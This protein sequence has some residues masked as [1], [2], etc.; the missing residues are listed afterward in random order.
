MRQISG[1]YK[2][3]YDIYTGL[4]KSFPLPIELNMK[5]NFIH[6]NSHPKLNLLI[7]NYPIEDIAGSG[8]DFSKAKKLLHWVSE[9]IYHNGESGPIAKNSLSL[10]EYSFN[11]GIEKG[12]NCVCLSIVLTEC[13]LAIGLPAK[14]VFIMPC[15]PYD[16]DNHCVTQV[17]IR[18]INNWVILDPTFNAYFNNEQGD[19]L[20]LLELRAHLANQEPIYFNDEAKYNDEIWGTA[21]SAEQNI[22]YFAK[23]LFFFQSSEIS[24][25]DAGNMPNNRIITL[26]PQ[27]YDPKQRRLN[28]IVYRI[29]KSGDCQEMQTWKDNAEKEEYCYCSIL[30]F[31]KKPH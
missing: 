7:N 12:I 14:K 16:G 9:N 10:L 31:E 2:M 17:Y 4:L 6:D 8:D 23:N 20:S 13:L 24:T 1:G 28:N 30:D 5:I 26:S 25:F 15:S 29:K 22:E 19:Y 3:S 18:E 11:K 21:E 27:G